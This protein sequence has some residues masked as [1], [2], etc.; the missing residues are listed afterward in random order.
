MWV[1]N[2]D[3]SSQRAAFLQARG[4]ICAFSLWNARTTSSAARVYMCRTSL[5]RRVERG[6]V[7][8]LTKDFHF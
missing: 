4:K 7:Q 8:E 1:Q 5:P 3:E 2:F 6:G